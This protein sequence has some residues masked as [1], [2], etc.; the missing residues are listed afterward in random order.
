MTK[1]FRLAV[2]EGVLNCPH[3]AGLIALD[4]QQVIASLGDY[5]VGDELLASH[6]ID[7]D[8]KALEVVP[9]QFGEHM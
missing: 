3:Q 9:T 5:L 2:Q 8:E 1:R 4:R 7:A 6:G